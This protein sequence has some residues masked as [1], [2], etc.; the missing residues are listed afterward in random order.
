MK[1]N[2]NSFIIKILSEKKNQFTFTLK[3]DD[4]TNQETQAIVNAANSDLLLGAGVAG[5]IRNK[6]GKKIQDYCDDIIKKENDNKSLDNGEVAYT[7]IGA[8]TNKNLK[9]IFHAVGPYYMD[10]KTDEEID[11]KK[12][13]LNCFK[14]ADKLKLNNISI[15]PISTGIFGFPKDKGAEVFFT[16]LEK[17]YEIFLNQKDCNNDS[18]DDKDNNDSNLL[19]KEI[20]D[21]QE[22][23]IENETE[24]KS[25]DDIPKLNNLNVEQSEESKLQIPTKNCE[26]DIKF[27]NEFAETDNIISITKF[28]KKSPNLKDNSKTKPDNVKKIMK[29]DFDGDLTLILENYTLDSI[30]LVIIDYLTYDIFYKKLEQMLEIWKKN[31]VYEI[32]EERN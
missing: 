22:N 21:N 28:D 12:S 26:T 1:S 32:Q 11:L 24:K 3:K 23:L 30:D 6:G 5:A 31:N 15:P 10:G 27:S 16:C 17:Y 25:E 20:N 9:Y 8:F 14:L 2:K 4:L 13:F 7:D 29:N 18:K 19:T